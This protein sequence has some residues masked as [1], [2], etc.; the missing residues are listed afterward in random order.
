MFL[1]EYRWEPSGE[2]EAVLTALW[3][4]A[5]LILPVLSLT[6]GL[7]EMAGRVCKIEAEQ[8]QRRDWKALLAGYLP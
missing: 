7:C 8:G 3:P 2:E 5:C 4:R 1:R 6:P